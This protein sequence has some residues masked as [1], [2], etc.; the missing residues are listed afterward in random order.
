MSCMPI[1]RHV[2]GLFT[3]TPDGRYPGL[4]GLKEIG[5]LTAM[6]GGEQSSSSVAESLVSN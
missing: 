5:K 2:G 6:V 4:A 3:G 1:H